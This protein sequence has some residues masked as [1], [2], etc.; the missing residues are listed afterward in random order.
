[1]NKNWRLE[2]NYLTQIEIS[3]MVC[4]FTKVLVVV[5]NVLVFNVRSKVMLAP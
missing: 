1:M 5:T 3:A 4:I 2:Q